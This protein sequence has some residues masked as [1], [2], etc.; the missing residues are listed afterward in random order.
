MGNSLKGSALFGYVAQKPKFL[1]EDLIQ[2]G[3]RSRRSQTEWHTCLPW[4]F[5]MSAAAVFN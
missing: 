5:S 1:E 4:I 2:W 3:I